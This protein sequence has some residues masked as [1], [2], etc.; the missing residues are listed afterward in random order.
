MKK[1]YHGPRKFKKKGGVH[2][3]NTVLKASISETLYLYLML[4]TAEAY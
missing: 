4:V 3:A 1:C 2:K